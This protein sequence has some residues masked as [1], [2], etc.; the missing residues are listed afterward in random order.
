MLQFIIVGCLLFEII[1]LYD[2]PDAKIIKYTIPVRCTS[3]QLVKE[4]IQTVNI[5]NKA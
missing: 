3:D 5:W 4:H 1:R 2:L